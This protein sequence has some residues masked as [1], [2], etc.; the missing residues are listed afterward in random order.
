VIGKRATQADERVQ[1][2]RIFLDLIVF[3]DYR[4]PFLPSGFKNRPQLGTIQKKVL[5]EPVSQKISITKP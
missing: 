1:S 2:S 5:S 4:P 3:V